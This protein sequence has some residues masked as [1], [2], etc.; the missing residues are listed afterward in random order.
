M[1]DI[2]G[3]RIVGDM[4][5]SD[6]DRWIDR[7]SAAFPGGKVVDRRERPSHG[8]RAVHYVAPV[9]EVRV[10]IQVRTVM[11]DLWAQIVERLADR[12]GRGIRYGKAVPDR[13][14]VVWGTT[15]RQHLVDAV[16][17][18]SVAVHQA[19][20]ARVVVSDLRHAL[21]R[22]T[23][24]GR[25]FSPTVEPLRGEVDEFEAQLRLRE[26]TIT[27]LLAGMLETAASVQ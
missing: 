26:A 5:W 25:D 24:W 18:L 12:W 22:P 1:D 6:Q 19:E 2:A 9:D 8:Y 4:T 11:Q 27:T 7:L 3:A 16:H 10:E 20:W 14:S 15:T 13:N 23:P 21:D 17:A